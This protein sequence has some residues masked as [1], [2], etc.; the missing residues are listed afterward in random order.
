MGFI[1]D[2]FNEGR[3]EA[4]QKAETARK[5]R[6]AKQNCEHPIKITSVDKLKVIFE[7]TAPE[8]AIE[9]YAEQMKKMAEKLGA[10][11]TTSGTT[12]T[13]ECPNKDVVK[14][15]TKVWK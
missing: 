7:I 10:K 4:R 8:P 13:Y 5:R 2:S 14:A 12:V 9:L 15:I 6:K 1:K 3:D 11:A